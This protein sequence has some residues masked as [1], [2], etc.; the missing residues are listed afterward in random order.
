MPDKILVVDDEPDILNLAKMILEGEGYDVEVTSNGKDALQKAE[1][2][3]DLILLDIVMPGRSGFE[4]CK[5]L[6]AGPKTSF[7]PV[8]M[9]TALGRDVDKKLSAESGAN[10][11]LVKPFTPEGLLAEVEK[12]LGRARLER[13]SRA[14][15]LSH[16]QLKGRKILFEFDP[17]TA[18]QRAV[19]DF[20]FEAR[21][22]G[23]A[24]LVLT[25]K[26]SVVRRTLQGEEGVEFITLAHQTMFSFMLQS[27]EGKP[28]ALI[29]DNLT[30]QI[31]FMG[32]QSTY[33]FTR[34]TLETLAQPEVT[35]LFL[36]NPN[37]HPTSETFI[38]RNLFSEQVTYGTNGLAKVKLT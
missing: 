18:Y 22:Q 7:I 28:L 9:F 32:F 33:N 13:F 31:L 24:V 10:G 2:E 30:D 36:F 15:G 14:L 37:A 23:E 3:P 26:A 8:V 25:P 11:H 29:F 20:A 12:H 35:V 16:A 1:Q 38:I 19:R 5:A 27:Y 6:K 34:N 21:A 4:V 17:A